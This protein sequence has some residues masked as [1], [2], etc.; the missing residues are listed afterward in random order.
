MDNGLLTKDENRVVMGL[1][2][3]AYPYKKGYQ[4]GRP[5]KRCIIMAVNLKLAIGAWW[6]VGR[7]WV[8]RHRGNL[9]MS[10][11]VDKSKTFN[12]GSISD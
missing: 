1:V 6:Q 12:T 9:D 4:E 5:I 8:G 10:E 7:L 3:G 2:T 11:R